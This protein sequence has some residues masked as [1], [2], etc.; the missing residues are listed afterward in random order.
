[1]VDP[2]ADG[3]ALAVSFLPKPSAGYDYMAY[4][5]SWHEGG[6]SDSMNAG[7]HPAAELFVD[8]FAVQSHLAVRKAW[9]AIVYP[10]RQSCEEL[11]K[12]D[13][14]WLT[15]VAIFAIIA[16]VI[17]AVAA[18]WRHSAGSAKP[19]R[20]VGE[21]ESGTVSLPQDTG[22][23]SPLAATSPARG[24]SPASASPAP[25]I[26]AA[27]EAEAVA[28]VPA[29]TDESP[30]RAI[31]EAMAGGGAE[32]L[33][34]MTERDAA[35]AERNAAAA[36]RD[37]AV[38]ERDAAISTMSTSQGELL[39]LSSEVA[40]AT[41]GKT[42][43]VQDRQQALEA[44]DAAVR[45]RDAAAEARDAAV[46]ER[47]AAAEARDAAVRERDAAAEARDAS[48]T[49][50]GSAQAEWQAT[51]AERARVID[52]MGEERHLLVA[53]RDAVMVERD[54]LR[55]ACAAA[56]VARAALEASAKVEESERMQAAAEY[57][58]Q[59][60]RLTS[61][62]MEQQA[63]PMSPSFMLEQMREAA[64]C[65]KQADAMAAMAVEE[66]LDKER[67]ARVEAA[68]LLRAT[69]AEVRLPA[70]P[71]PAPARA[72]RLL[73][74]C[75]CSCPAQR[76]STQTTGA[77][78]GEPAHFAAVLSAVSVSVLRVCHGRWRSACSLRPWQLRMTTSH[79]PS[80][81][82]TPSWKSAALGGARTPTWRTR[83]RTLG[84]WPQSNR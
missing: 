46:R 58:R 10:A 7:C 71:C 44:R 51:M 36:E 79:P 20:G 78:E 76:L 16:V 82:C 72:L 77:Y 43:A 32:E 80:I 74:P 65:R 41:N 29:A 60:S 64:Q 14:V 66:S 22:E 69:H 8:E 54:E 18:A 2:L 49:Q 39:A 3:A 19:S 13:Q 11:A 61:R 42:Q 12:S 34:A 26:P 57:E 50:R 47:D 33:A 83:P 67:A 40:E 75:A 53:Q 35:A 25:H 23:S 28:H 48:L 17:T 38:A 5:W 45:E 62:V 52:G 55:S 27:V 15:Q 59:I 31:E 73:V 4:D 1:M 6:T 70:P 37:A 81:N 56:E 30:R 84:R 24:T 68:L 63:T 9:T 21:S